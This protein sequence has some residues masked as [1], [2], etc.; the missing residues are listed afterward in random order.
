MM[1]WTPGSKIST[2]ITGSCMLTTS[3]LYL[4][5]LASTTVRE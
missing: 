4:P 3:V 5:I 1:L 2:I